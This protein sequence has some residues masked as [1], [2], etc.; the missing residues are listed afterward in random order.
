MGKGGRLQGHSL[1]SQLVVQGKELVL[2][3]QERAVP[4]WAG[5]QK[6]ARFYVEWKTWS[7]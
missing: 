6:G 5:L 7:P 3:G 2:Q 4:R 1:L